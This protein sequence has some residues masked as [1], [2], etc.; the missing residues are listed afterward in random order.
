MI[1]YYFIFTGPITLFIV[2]VTI[3]LIHAINHNETVNASF[4]ANRFGF[5]LRAEQKS[6]NKPANK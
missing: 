3:I 4:W 6:D 1:L 2:A 5:S